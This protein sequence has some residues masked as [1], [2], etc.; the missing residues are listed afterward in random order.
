MFDTIATLKS[1]KAEYV[2][3]A[4]DDDYPGPE[5]KKIATVTWHEYE[6]LTGALI[7]CRDSMREDEL[8][9]HKA[10]LEKRLSALNEAVAAIEAAKK[11]INP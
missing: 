11:A 6:R 10:E 1:V 3:D 8:L 2:I 9:A 4:K 5:K 7:E